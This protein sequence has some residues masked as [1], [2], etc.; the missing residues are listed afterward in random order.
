[1]DTNSDT[2]TNSASWTGADT[3]APAMVREAVGVFDTREA[4]QNAIDELSLAGFERHELSLMAD[5]ETIRNE[6]GHVPGSAE[7]AKHDPAMPRQSYV[8]PEETGSAQGAAIGIPAYVGAVLATGAALATGGTALAAAAAAAAAGAAGGGLGGILSGWVGDQR[9]E[10][11]RQ[12][13]EKG[14]ILLWVNLRNDE[15]ER[16]ARDILARHTNLPVDVHE[17][18]QAAAG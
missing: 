2:Q 13:L 18:A 8:S 12:H 10:P 3:S 14:G 9:N 6:L 4:L 15:R 16:V 5:D 11:L 7:E 1:M 17:V